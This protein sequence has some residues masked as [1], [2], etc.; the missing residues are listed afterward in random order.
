MVLWLLGLPFAFVVTLGWWSIIVCTVVGYELLGF[1]TIGVEI[2]N[3]FGR[4]YNDLP[5]DAVS[6]HAS[7]AHQMLLRE[8]NRFTSAA[9]ALMWHNAVP[10]AQMVGTC[11]EKCMVVYKKSPSA[12]LGEQL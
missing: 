7:N 8:H 9:A 3:P 2:E 4:D 1:E 6:L 10:P 11:I 12:S 5:L